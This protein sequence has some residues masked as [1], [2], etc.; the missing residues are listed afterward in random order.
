MSHITIYFAD[1]PVYLCDEI[2]GSLLELKDKKD[3]LYGDSLSNYYL[4]SIPRNIEKPEYT[5]AVLLYP[6]L[7]ALQN[8]F[9]DQ[10]KLVTAGGGIVENEKDEILLIF[11][12]SKWDLPKGKSDH[13][14]SIMDCALREVKEETGIRNVTIGDQLDVTYHVYSERGTLV[15]KES[16]WFAMAA[17]SEEVLTPQAD[18]GI[19]EIIWVKKKDIANYMDRTYP[20][21]RD[22]LQL[23]AG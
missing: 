3:V 10:F 4:Q 8:S 11:R 17:S 19:T 18:E 14:E 16:H 9:F 7:Q 22:L 2:T 1:K 12:N 15:L 23:F 6:D 5:A 13:G 20:A 21:I